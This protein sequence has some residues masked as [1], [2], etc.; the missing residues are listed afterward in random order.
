MNAWLIITGAYVVL[1][2]A[3]QGISL[4]LGEIVRPALLARRTRIALTPAVASIVIAS[5]FS[6]SPPALTEPVKL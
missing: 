4:R 5:F 3:A 6:V 2:A 1:M